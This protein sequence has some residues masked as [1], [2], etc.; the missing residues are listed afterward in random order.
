MEP[1]S[2]FLVQILTKLRGENKFVSLNGPLEAKM[3][4]S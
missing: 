3:Q 2:L 4:L 1:K